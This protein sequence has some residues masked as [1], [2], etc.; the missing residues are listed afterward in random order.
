MCLEDGV[1]RVV[2][3][4]GNHTQVLTLYGTGFLC[5]VSVIALTSGISCCLIIVIIALIL[6]DRFVQKLFGI[7]VD[8][9]EHGASVKS[10]SLQSL[11]FL[12]Q[13]R[14]TKL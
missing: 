3:N 8:C 11:R 13:G 4:V 12:K 6:L 1:S 7:L 9:K 2:S 10:L 5:R 14:K